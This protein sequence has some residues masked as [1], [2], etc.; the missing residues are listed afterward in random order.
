MGICLLVEPCGLPDSV[1]SVVQV[2]RTRRD[3]DAIA[4]LRHSEGRFRQLWTG[5]KVSGSPL[6]RVRAKRRLR[7]ADVVRL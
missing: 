7:R 3:V 6:W 1:R 4:V 5:S 2:R